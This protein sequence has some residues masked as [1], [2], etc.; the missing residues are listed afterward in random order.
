LDVAGRALL[1][2]R[3]LGV[4]LLTEVETDGAR[5]FLWTTD[6]TL[7]TLSSADGKEAR[8]PIRGVDSAP[9]LSGGRLY[10]GAA[11]GVLV[12]AEAATGRVLKRIE[13]GEKQSVRA[14]MIG[15]TLYAGAAGGR[16]VKIDPRK[17]IARVDYADY[18]SAVSGLDFLC[19]FRGRDSDRIRQGIPE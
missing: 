11:G 17:E 18:S 15:G 4:G 10:W 2:E 7:L 3:S 19:G 14:L 5:V 16:I 9:L 8:E 13:T 1:W 6:R 12:V